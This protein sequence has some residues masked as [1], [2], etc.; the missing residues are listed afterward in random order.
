MDWPPDPELPCAPLPTGQGLVRPHAATITADPDGARDLREVPR[1]SQGQGS[2]TERGAA[3]YGGRD[4]LLGTGQGGCG[5]LLGSVACKGADSRASKGTG[6]EAAQGGSGA[7]LGA[8]G[9]KG[10]TGEASWRN[11]D[12]GA[13]ASQG[14]DSEDDLNDT[15]QG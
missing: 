1:A 14:G 9:S 13:Q 15:V 12:D 2:S 6:G 8:R 5:G 7:G 3:G 4:G 10:A 11:E